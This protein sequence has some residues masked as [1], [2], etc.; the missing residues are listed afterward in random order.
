MGK[1]RAPE[2]LHGAVKAVKESKPWAHMLVEHMKI[3]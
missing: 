3:L 1:R 2:D